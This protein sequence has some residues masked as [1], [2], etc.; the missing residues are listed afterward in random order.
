MFHIL[1]HLLKM[2][3]A[4]ARKSPWLSGQSSVLEPA[5][6]GI[7]THAFVLLQIFIYLIMIHQF[8]DTFHD[9]CYVLGDTKF[10]Y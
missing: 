10:L 5:K 7:K 6:C 3:F 4:P 2:F 9:N 8:L 1:L